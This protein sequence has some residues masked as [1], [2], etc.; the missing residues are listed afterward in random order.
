M[1]F[2]LTTISNDMPDFENH[3][4]ARD[5][6]KEQ[7]QDRFSLRNSDVNNGEKVYYYHLIKKPEM[8][9]EYMDSFAK[10]V[11]HEITHMETFESY[12]T[13]EISED[14]SVSLTL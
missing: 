12:S 13:V 14:G 7:F 4:Q 6:F 5:W 9:Q 3:L 10:P 2:D 11:K 1:N 8:Y